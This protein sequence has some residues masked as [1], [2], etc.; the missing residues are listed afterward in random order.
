MEDQVHKFRCLHNF[1]NRIFFY[2]T[3]LPIRELDYDIDF[4]YLD[5][6]PREDWY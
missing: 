4:G 5:A 2:L 1:D 3:T 6:L